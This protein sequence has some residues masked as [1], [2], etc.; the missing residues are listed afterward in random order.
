M[1]LRLRSVVGYPP[2]L[3]LL[4]AALSASPEARA[5]NPEKPF[6]RAPYLQFA[7]PTLMHVVWRTEGPIDAV[8]RYGTDPAKLDREVRGGGAI[9]VRAALT[10][11]TAPFPAKWESL[12]TPANLA[13][14]KL[15][16]APVGTFQYEAKIKDLQPETTYY[17]G[18][19]D[20]A[21]QLTPNDQSYRFTTH[22][23]PG[24]ERPTRFW[25]IGDGGTGREPQAAVHRAMEATVAAEKHP[26]DFWIHVGDMAYNT[27]RDNEF[28]TRFFEMYDST[29]RNKV[30]WPAMGNHEGFTSSGKTGVGPYYDAYVVPTRGESG[31]VASGTEAYYSFD[32]ANVHFICLDSHDLSRKPG[33]P[34]ANWLKADLEKAKADW[35]IAFWHH[36]PYTKGSHDSDKETD[37][38]E[39]RKLIMPIAEAGGVDLVLTGHSHIYERSM[40]MDGAYATP[41]VSENVILDDGDG[42][43]DGDGAYRKSKG[44]KAHEGTVQIVTGNAGQTLSRNGTMPVMRRILLENGSVLIDVK[45]DTLTGR[46]ITR[47]GAEAD[48]FSI[49]KRGK[50]TT[51]RN[52]LPW[53]APEYKKPEN[54]PKVAAVP[55][56]DHKT[57][58]PTGAEWTYTFDAPIRGKEWAQPGFAAAEWKSGPSA[59][60]YGKGA[61]RTDLREMRRRHTVLYARR[62][63]EIEQADR[64]TEIGLLIDFSDA[65]IAYINGE[66]VVRNG[67]GRSSGRNA[68]NVKVREQKGSAVFRPARPAE[69][70]QGR[71]QRARHRGAQQQRGQGGLSP[72]PSPHRRRLMQRCPAHIAL[73]ALLLAG[74]P[75]IASG[76]AGPEHEIEELTEEMQKHGESAGL[77]TERAIEYRVLGK[78]PEATKDLERAALLDRNSTT[79]AREL[80]RVL[81]LDHKAGDA[82]AVISRGLTLKSDEPTDAA[83]LRIL[84]AEILRS[85]NENRKRSRTATRRC[86]CT[87]R[88]RSGTSCAATCRS[89]SARTGSGSRGSKWAFAKRAQACWKSSAW[90]R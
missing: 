47:D 57:V 53:L 54:A 69:A 4:L 19:F 83:S 38:T 32:Y 39:M 43:P 24:P 29:L 17:Y 13:L 66:E 55:A 44:L 68:Q 34:M 64:V 58:I 9:V 50:V 21:K 27:G 75:F 63:F 84:R 85:Q 33:D 87:H 20:G 30:C 73:L 72:Q 35:L 40:L 70:A 77:L 22:P 71:G 25:V 79:I 42:D 6:S 18:V 51:S 26:L 3:S 8:V 11:K 60:G 90:K 15:H 2:F 82:L 45:G 49:V 74:A 12:R 28:Q 65:F 52:P 76:H 81:F 7:S 78:L 56:V 88:I 59:F 36:P 16:S 62:T 48:S 61:F 14:P 41:T 1:S 86:V 37:L 31:G 10:T 5:V 46:M 23:K 67:V 80:A 89:G